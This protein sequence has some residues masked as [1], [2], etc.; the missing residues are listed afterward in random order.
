MHRRPTTAIAAPAVHVLRNVLA[1]RAGVTVR[2]AASA[3]SHAVLITFTFKGFKGSKD[4]VLKRAFP[5]G[6]SLQDVE[7]V[8]EELDEEV[9]CPGAKPVAEMLLF[10]LS[11]CNHRMR[12]TCSQYKRCD[13]VLSDR[14]AVF[15][16]NEAWT[17]WL[18][19]KTSEERKNVA[20][21]VAA[22][23]CLRAE[24]RN[25]WQ[26]RMIDV[27]VTCTTP[28]SQV[29]SCVKAFSSFKPNDAVKLLQLEGPMTVGHD[30]FQ[31]DDL[32]TPLPQEVLD[33]GCADTVRHMYGP[34]WQHGTGDVQGQKS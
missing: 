11:P 30:V 18:R 20:L 6:P 33:A 4:K 25:G 29:E 32:S 17:L 10:V 19:S 7:D 27:Q 34:G 23:I 13:F 12:C 28:A 24:R 31:L 5:P 21:Q 14:D 8:V 26:A 15:N 16:N 1:Q 22:C 2:I 9:S 3:H